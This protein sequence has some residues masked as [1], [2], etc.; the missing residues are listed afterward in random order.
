MTKTNWKNK[1]KTVLEKE[2]FLGL[3]T[4]SPLTK[5]DKTR[6]KL[7]SSVNVS[8][9]LVDTFKKTP[10][11][12]E[13]SGLVSSAFV[14]GG[15]VDTSE[16]NELA[17]IKTDYFHDVLNRLIENGVVFDVSTDDFKT[18][19]SNKKLKK[20]DIELF[21]LN[22]TSILCTL[23]QSLL[24]KHLFNHSPEQFEDFAFEIQ[25][26]ESFF[27]EVPTKTPLTI[28]DKTPIEIRQRE[29]FFSEVSTNSALT[30]ADKTPF[31]IYCEA[32]KCVTK[33]WFADLLEKKGGVRQGVGVR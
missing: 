3:P 8:G 25:E 19:D 31:E 11:L 5:A 22:Y 7:V 30:K 17:E 9:Q 20:G 18:I 27:S 16:K 1:L 2:E 13:E 6:I 10:G 12:N 14:S 4:N 29:A 21:E 23:Q 24:M 28:T 33:R 26:R 32:V 15:L